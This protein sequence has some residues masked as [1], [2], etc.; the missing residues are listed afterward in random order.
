[1]LKAALVGVAPYNRDSGRC[2]GKRMI[3]GGRSYL[4]RR[5]F[6]MAAV[7]ASRWNPVIRAFYQGWFHPMLHQGLVD[8]VA[9]PDLGKF[10]DLDQLQD[11]D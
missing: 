5:L 8:P 4:R 6:Y 11:I 2:R 1:M 3:R 7:V 9:Q 10:L